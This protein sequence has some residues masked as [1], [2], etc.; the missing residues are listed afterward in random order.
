ME[1]A[2]P[3]V[4]IQLAAMTL[5]LQPTLLQEAVMNPLPTILGVLVGPR[6]DNLSVAAVDD[7]VRNSW[8]AQ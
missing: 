2:F 4:A 5:L 6:V 3:S 1:E 8:E 7:L